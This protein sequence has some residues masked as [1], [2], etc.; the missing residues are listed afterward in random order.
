MSKKQIQIE[1][2]NQIKELV[3][4]KEKEQN[5]IVYNSNLAI[6]TL[7][8][9][10]EQISNTETVVCSRLI[11]EYIPITERRNMVEKE[12]SSAFAKHF[13]E[14][15]IVSINNLGVSKSTGAIKYEAKFTFIRGCENE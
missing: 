12:F 5:P 4:R 11:P 10:I 6:Q 7:N 14:N 9:I 15:K 3:F 1:L 2:L 8:E 13:I